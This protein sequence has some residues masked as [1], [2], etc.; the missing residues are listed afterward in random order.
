MGYDRYQQVAIIFAQSAGLGPPRLE[1]I[2][3]LA[4]INNAYMY[5]RTCL[6]RPTFALRNQ[7]VRE[8]A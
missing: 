4:K 1:G 2:R 8:L 6:I 5:W 7:E 3:G